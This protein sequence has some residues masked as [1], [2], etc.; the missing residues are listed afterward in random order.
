MPA[1]EL[2][3]FISTITISFDEGVAASS[4]PRPLN[5]LSQADGRSQAPSGGKRTGGRLSNRNPLEKCSS[6]F[7]LPS[8]P[9]AW[10]A[11]C[12]LSC[13]VSSAP[14]HLSSSYYLPSSLSPWARRLRGCFSGPFGLHQSLVSEIFQHGVLPARN[15][16]MAGGCSNQA[17]KGGVS[18]PPRPTASLD[19]ELLEKCIFRETQQWNSKKIQLISASKIFLQK[20]GTKLPPHS[21]IMAKRAWVLE[22]ERLGSPSLN[23][24]A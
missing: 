14:P 24:V 10:E 6:A 16:S 17:L 1:L 13:S 7:Q 18:P 20:M 11:V 23:S 15:Q 21:M 5:C 12:W 3:T 19:S 22:S 4:R 9:S 8:K 2:Q